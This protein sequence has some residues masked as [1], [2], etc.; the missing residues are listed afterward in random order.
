LRLG[1]RQIKGLREEDAMRLL[2]VRK[3]IGRFNSM[4]QIQITA[5]L[6]AS[7][8]TRL[9]K[10]DALT[11]LDLNRR[12]GAWEAMGL[13]DQSLPLFDEVSQ[14][15]PHAMATLPVMPAEDE[16][17]AD[18]AT[19]GLSL[20]RHPVSFARNILNR[21]RVTPAADIRD[22][23][24]FP[25]G[26]HICI[27]GL[28]LVRQ[29]P[30]TASGVVFITLEDETGVANLIVWPSVYERYRRD[31]RYSTLLQANGIVQREGQVIHVVAKRLID[32]T[33]LLS[34]L[35]QSSRDFH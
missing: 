6:H 16:V 33:Q 23:E 8:L 17:K 24:R 21:W 5:G 27:A 9:A 7:T 10:A 29:R 13:A 1:F 3:N 35:S 11:S 26:C 15:L 22:A 31:T 25:N 4:S 12:R 18:Y 2:T 20:K 28:V 30:G 14:N 32:R 34:G 19:I